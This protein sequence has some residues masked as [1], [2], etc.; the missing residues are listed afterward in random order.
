M[1]SRT[2]SVGVAMIKAEAG[3]GTP[4][5]NLELLESLAL[6]LAGK[7]IDVLITPECFLDGYMVRDEKKCTRRKLLA[8]CVTGP[9]DPAIR[10][11]ARLARKLQCYVVFGASE[12]DQAGDIRNA[13]FLLDRSGGHVGTYYK[14]QPGEFYRPGDG[15]PV[16]DTDF[17]LVGIVICADRRWPEVIRCLRIKGAQIILNPT[18][19]FKG[20]LNQAIIRTRA[21]ENCIPVCFTHPRES[22]IC[23]KDGSVGALLDSSQADVLVHDVEIGEPVSFQRHG[24]AENHPGHV[25]RPETYSA[26]LE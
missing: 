3:W 12:R 15:L 25:R 19:G 10:R 21:Y 5:A 24:E 23:L 16:F 26:L 13:A 1:P 20:D 6:P 8:R 17:G 9:P 11:V 2:R 4:Q 14:A 18:W 7:G 22:L